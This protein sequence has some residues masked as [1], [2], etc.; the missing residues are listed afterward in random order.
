MTIKNLIKFILFEKMLMSA[1]ELMPDFKLEKTNI[2]F[3]ECDGLNPI[4]Y[5]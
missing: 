1:F 5:V 3:Y 4:R 2:D